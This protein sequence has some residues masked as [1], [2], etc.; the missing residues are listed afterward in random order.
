M[1]ISLEDFYLYRDEWKLWRSL[2][3]YVDVDNVTWVAPISFAEASDMP[4][5]MLDVFL[6]LDGMLSK[7]RAQFLKQKAKE[8]G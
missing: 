5:A 6:T 3:H 1:D 8:N 2:G 4:R 7:M